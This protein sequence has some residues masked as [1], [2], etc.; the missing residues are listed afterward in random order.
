MIHI[1]HMM[2]RSRQGKSYANLVPMTVLSLGLLTMGLI[3]FF[4][5]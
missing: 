2:K 5:Q 1:I 4:N 3:M